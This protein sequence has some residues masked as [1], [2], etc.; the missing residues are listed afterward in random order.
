MFI[1]LWFY[2]PVLSS[3]IQRA[4]SPIIKVHSLLNYIFMEE[5]SSHF[6]I[7]LRA[8]LSLLVCTLPLRTVLS[9][10]TSNG[11]RIRGIFEVFQTLKFATSD[12]YTTSD[13]GTIVHESRHQTHVTAAGGLHHCSI[14][15]RTLPRTGEFTTREKTLGTTNIKM[16]I[17]GP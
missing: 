12:Y 13:A 16:R 15:S 3:S 8:V 5:C 10:V 1:Y 2:L 9:M 4:L 11:L 17:I 7:G 6:I 14:S